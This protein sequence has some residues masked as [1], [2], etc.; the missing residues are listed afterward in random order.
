MELPLQTLPF[1]SFSKTNRESKPKVRNAFVLLSPSIDVKSQGRKVS[2]VSSAL[3][4]TAASVAVAATVVGAAASLLVRRTKDS[5]NK[6]SEAIEPS[7]VEAQIPLTV[8][9]DCG[10]SGI[11]SECNGEGFVLKKLSEES[12]EKARLTA[13]NAGHSIHGRASK[14]MELLYKM[15]FCQI[16]SYLWWPWEVKLILFALIIS[17]L[18]IGIGVFFFIFT[19]LLKNT[20]SLQSISTVS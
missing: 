18:L 20:I 16:L 17:M 19:L 2:T 11:C 1:A 14:E 3:L 12:A 5:E 9:E 13:K 7:K 4:E 10:G 8:C 6:D 15:L